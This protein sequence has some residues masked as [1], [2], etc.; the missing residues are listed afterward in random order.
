MQLHEYPREG[1]R[2]DFD[3]LM[4]DPYLSKKYNRER[5]IKDHRKYMGAFTPELKHVKGKKIL[6]IGCAMGEYLEICREFG[7]EIQGVDAPL[8]DCEMGNEYIRL[9]KLMTER[10]HIPV[11]YCGLQAWLNKAHAAGEYF[12]INMRGCIEQCF[13]EHQSGTPHR[14]THNA[15][16]LKWIITKELQDKFELMFKMFSHIL[17]DG[18]RIAIWANG[19]KNNPEYDNLILETLKKFPELHLVKKI[20]KLQHKI[21][22]RV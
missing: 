19:S 17:E 13:Y 1:W 15:G 12:Y 16:G 14:V 21:Q 8:E 22:K 11:D 2:K 18:G 3:G 4:K 10:Q 6:D 20:G 5:R 7:H 9:S